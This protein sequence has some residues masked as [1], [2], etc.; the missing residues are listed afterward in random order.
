[1]TYKE[2]KTELLNNQ[3]SLQ[4]FSIH[5]SGNPYDAGDLIQETY[6]KALKN[7]KQF[8]ENDRKNLRAWLFTIMKNTFINNY[9]RNKRR[10]E[11]N[12][13]TEEKRKEEYFRMNQSENPESLYKV[14]EID[15]LVDGLSETYRRPFILYLNGYKYKEI[16]EIL[17]LN[18]GTVK[19]RI[20]LSRKK[21]RN[22][23]NR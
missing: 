19:S 14:N 15:S 4:A 12:S 17:N 23:L 2:F 5:L 10:Q 3:E 9:R 6:F 18:L 8:L 11:H 7:K 22:R 16:A 21:L 13:R 20:F 1:M